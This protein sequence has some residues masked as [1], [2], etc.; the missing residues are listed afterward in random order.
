MSAHDSRG[1]VFIT[2]LDLFS[3]LLFAFI[4]VT[5]AD[6]GMASDMAT[7][8]L[9]AVANPAPNPTP[10]ATKTVFLSWSGG[11]PAATRAAPCRVKV[12]EGT[13]EFDVDVQCLPRAF[14]SGVTH[15]LNEKLL[16]YAGGGFRAV[17]LCPSSGE[18]SALSACARL[19]W[20]AAE[21]RLQ[22]IA[23]IDNTELSR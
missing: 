19:Q 22:T 1:D 17:L 9:P 11:P 15:P 16:S 4:G 5:V 20:I 7:I 14:Y 21:H 2:A 18:E 23:A 6:E 12:R 10:D 8:D 13:N 3:L